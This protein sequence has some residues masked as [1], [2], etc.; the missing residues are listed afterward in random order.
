MAPPAPPPAP[1]YRR[2]RPLATDRL[3]SSGFAD[4]AA[5]AVM[6]SP[7]TRGPVTFTAKLGLTAGSVDPARRITVALLFLGDNGHVYWADR[8]FG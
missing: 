2:L 5:M 6:F 7:T 8:L 1:R 3:T 4:D